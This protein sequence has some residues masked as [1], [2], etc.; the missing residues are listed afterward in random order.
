MIIIIHIIIFHIC[1][2]IFSITATIITG[3]TQAQ[4]LTIYPT[5][6]HSPFPSLSITPP[7]VTDS[8]PP[9]ITINSP[10]GNYYP[11]TVSVP[12]D[13]SITDTESGVWFYNFCVDNYGCSISFPGTD[14]G[15]LNLNDYSYGTHVFTVDAEDKAGNWTS[16]STVYTYLPFATN[17]GTISGHVYNGSNEP[18]SVLERAYVD[19]CSESECYYKVTNTSGEYMADY[20]PPGGYTITVYSPDN[21]DLQRSTSSV[22]LPDSGSITNDSTLYPP[23]PPLLPPEGT[24]ITDNSGREIPHNEVPSVYWNDPLSLTTHGCTGGTATYV[25]IHSDETIRSGTMFE[26]PSGTYT[27]VIEPLY[28]YH[29]DARVE[30]TVTCPNNDPS[31]IP[32]DI[33]IDPSGT[34]KDQNGNPVDGATITLLRADD[35]T[36]QFEIVPNDSAIMSPANRHNP[37]ITNSKGSFGWDVIGGYYKVR[38]EKAGCVSPLNS[39]LGFVE[40]GLLTIPPPITDIELILFCV[41]NPPKIQSITVPQDPVSVQRAV[42]VNAQFSDPNAEDTL[43]AIWTWGDNTTSNG[44]VIEMNGSG[45]VSGSHTY[46]SAGVYTITLTV[47][48]KDNGKDTKTATSYVVIF[49]PSGGFV[50]GGG[51][52]NFPAGAYPKDPS[53]SGKASFGFVSKYQK[54]ANVPSGNTEFN[55]NNAKFI[56]KSTS[57]D[58]LVVAGAKA[59]YKGSGTINGSG[60]YGFILTVID[61][62]VNGG[63]GSDKFRIKIIDKINDKVIYDNKTGA[64]D[65]SDPSTT[66]QGSIVIHKD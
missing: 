1:I 3:R 52:I 11:S 47:K 19:I 37:D 44:V 35:I 22:I 46:G 63:G 58:W 61:G 53:L 21:E 2:V 15:S 23:P 38:T 18:A 27:A 54:G 25:V 10:A 60:D 49:D 40:T 48:D 5:P 41:S 65:N 6:T 57:Y 43:T 13:I 45:S 17:Y 29:D 66:V 62:Q 8:T 14:N 9:E 31:V 16:K 55:F 26:S 33:W 32:F 42:S 12:I 7:P 39:N 59:Q 51:S 36:G 4:M 20:L 28:P 64:D 30:I 34:V 24:E 56:F 50:T